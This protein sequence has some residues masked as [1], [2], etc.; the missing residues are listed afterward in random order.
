MSKLR[1][2]NTAIWGDVWFEELTIS[3]K[4]LFIYCITNEKTNMLGVYEI[5][6]RKISFETGIAVK[7]IE[8]SFQIF[9]KAKKIKYSDNR[10]VLLNYLKHQNYNFNMKKSAIEVYNS[11]PTGL[12]MQGISLIDKT[13]EGFE[14]LCDGFGCLSKIEVEDELEVKVEKKVIKPYRSFAHLSLSIEEYN[15]LLELGYNK[16][17]I[18][19]VLDKIENYK[20][21]NT[22]KSL[23]LTAKNWL[24]K[25]KGS[26]A[27][28]QPTSKIGKTQIACQQAHEIIKNTEIDLS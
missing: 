7:D 26:S 11:L 13:N 1:S 27:Q 12:K 9:Q 20:K 25:E 18:D 2:I 14:T 10:V 6:I 3:Q 24:K 28:N 4:L 15:N 8:K 5:S 17:E 21:N 22:Y 23:F 19:F 16:K